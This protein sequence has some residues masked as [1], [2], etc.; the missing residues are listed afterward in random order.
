MM[1]PL[2]GA[3]VRLPVTPEVA[4][5]I[6]KR[7]NEGETS[8]ADGNIPDSY[9]IPDTLD[10]N[11]SYSGSNTHIRISDPPDELVIM[12]DI[13]AAEQ[14]GTLMDSINNTLRVLMV[15]EGLLEEEEAL[16]ICKKFLNNP[17]DYINHPSWLQS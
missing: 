15:E 8:T 13:D 4:D 12:N 14:T 11:F 6:R 5:R 1:N 7:I 2:F 17:F 10:L 9:A 16:A 3:M